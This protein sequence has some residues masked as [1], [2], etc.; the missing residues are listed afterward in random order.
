[1]NDYAG[2]YLRYTETYK[3]PERWFIAIPPVTEELADVSFYQEEMDWDK[4][5]A[6]AVIIRIGQGVW[7]D[8]RFNENYFGALA[9]KKVIGGYWFYDGRYSPTEQARKIAE[10][11]FSKEFKLELFIDWERSY[12]GAYEGLR[13]VVTLMKM[14]EGMGLKVAGIG[15]YTGYYFFMENTLRD[16]D[17]YAY[18]SNKPL[19]LAWYA[20]PQVVK[21]PTPWV[22]TGWT[23]WQWGTPVVDW[24]QKTKELDMNHYNG[25]PAEFAAKYLGVTMPAVYVAGKTTANL[26]VRELPSTSSR[27]LTTLPLGT[28][29]AGYLENGW[30]SGTFNGFTGYILAQWTDAQPAVPPTSPTALDA[31]LV[32]GTDTYKGSLVKQ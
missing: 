11:M 27:I 15:I 23:Y 17:L 29:V 18:L 19:W 1:M 24:G 20:A 30:I 2:K 25:T 32:L 3:L 10:A 5:P 9:R 6:R 12:G 22:E 21:L 14:L 13:Y 28:A 31:T 16:Q 4:Y 7:I 26:N 8:P